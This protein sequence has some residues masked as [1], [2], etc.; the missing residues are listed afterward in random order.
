MADKSDDSL[1]W[2]EKYLNALDK[3]EQQEKKANTQQELLRRALVRVSV[4]ADG[5]DDAL[6][7]ILGQLRDRIRNAGD[8]KSVLIQL[9]EAVVN[10]EQQ[11]L[12]NAQKVRRSLADTM[13]PLQQ[14]EL[15]RTLKKEINQ[16][17]GQ[18]PQASKKV[19]LYPELLQQLANIQQQALK[20]LERPNLSLWQKLMGKP[21]IKK[22]EKASEPASRPLLAEEAN[23]IEKSDSASSSA[24]LTEHKNETRNYAAI[25]AEL[26][27]ENYADKDGQRQKKL[28]PTTQISPEFVNKANSILNQFLMQLENEAAIAKRAQ[29][30]RAAINDDSGVDKLLVNLEQVRDLVMQAYLLTNRDFAE[31][32][33]NVHQEL[34]NIYRVVDGVSGSRSVLQIASRKMQKN[35]VQEIKSLED[36]LDSATDLEQLKKQLNFQIGNIRQVFDNYQET[37]QEQKKLTEQLEL[38]SSKIKAMEVEAEKNRTILEKQRYKAL[39]DPLTELPNREGYS[40]RSTYEFQRWQRYGRALTIAVFDID[41]FKK[42]NDNY[43]HQAGDRVLKVIGSSIAKSLREVDFFCRFGGEEFVALM[44]ETGLEEAMLALDKIRIVIASASFSYKD[45]SLAITV[46]IGAAEFKAGDNL[47][48]AFVRADGALYLA[49]S[50]GRNCSRSA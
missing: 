5:Q 29:S 38:L 12:N 7:N 18:L 30:I 35:M 14:L 1:N 45:Q 15:S 17:L 33:K 44:P 37:E 43:G 19:R 8:I 47:E 26:M 42:I 20:E 23:E 48:S 9:D 2:R 27:A 11:R 40:E 28:L 13:K 24:S 46:S 6:D 34:A 4:S 31:Y 41:H 25:D 49:K 32:L 50:D 21:A 10:F 16:Y 36:S 39:H 22:I 3:Q